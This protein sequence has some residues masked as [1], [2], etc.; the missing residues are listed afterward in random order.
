VAHEISNPRVLLSGSHGRFY[1][2]PERA[3]FV[4]TSLW[5]DLTPIDYYL[6]KFND[7][8]W[9]QTDAWLVSRE[10]TEAAGPWLNTRSPDDDGEYFCR[11]V[12]KSDGVKF[13]DGAR[14]YFRI[15]D[16]KS[17]GHVRSPVALESL[18]ETIVLCIQYMSSIENSSRTRAAAVQLIQQWYP[19]VL[20]ERSAIAFKFE[21]LAGELGGKLHLPTVKWKYRPA[22]WLCGYQRALRLSRV[23]PRMKATVLREWDRRLYRLSRRS[24]KRSDPHSPHLNF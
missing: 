3:K 4:R 17:L 1:F 5:H 15:G 21:K 18:F 9:I 11:V 22:Q 7:S 13:V 23:L 19:E 14:S 2:R 24:F 20:N 10:L 8:V 6:T 12:Q 16:T